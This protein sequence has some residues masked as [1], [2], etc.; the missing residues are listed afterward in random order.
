[1]NQEWEGYDIRTFV[2]KYLIYKIT[3]YIKACSL[4]KVYMAEMSFHT[5]AV[6][7]FSLHFPTSFR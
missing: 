3:L 4:K 1:M 2:S 7:I 5:C 6:V